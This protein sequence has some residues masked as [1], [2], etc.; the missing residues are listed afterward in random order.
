MNAED[1]LN[2]TCLISLGILN[3]IDAIRKVRPKALRNIPAIKRITEPV[4]RVA[5]EI[6]DR[7]R[8]DLLTILT[9]CGCSP[10]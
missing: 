4:E 2:T 5:D 10:D 9:K 3:S 6:S 1:R 7:A 8:K